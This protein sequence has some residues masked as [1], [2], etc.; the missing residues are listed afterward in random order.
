MTGRDDVPAEA[1]VAADDEAPQPPQP[2]RHRRLLLFGVVGVLA[3]ALDIV[4]KALV[5]SNVSQTSAPDRVLGGVL[6]LQQV[7]NSGAAFSLG[8]GFTVILTVVALAVVV[9]IVRVAA[10]LR[11]AGWA[12]SLGLILGGALG[13]LTDRLFRSPG[14][15]RGHVVDWI[16][17]FGPDG[18]YWPIFNLADSAIVC[19]AVLAAL[20]AVIGIEFDGRRSRRG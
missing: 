11:S 5:V 18:K 8:T 7:R 17:L 13:N 14:V 6:Y 9:L 4:S 20:L 3:L 10:R 12:V 15:G 16:S 2:Q 1:P 19:G